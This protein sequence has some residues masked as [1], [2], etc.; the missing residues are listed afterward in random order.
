MWITTHEQNSIQWKHLHCTSTNWTFLKFQK[1]YFSF[2]NK[3][4]C[5]QLG[6]AN[7]VYVL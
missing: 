5:K 3:L 1:C 6:L 4:K 7:A 2:A